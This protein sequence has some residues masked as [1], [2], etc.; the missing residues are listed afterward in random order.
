MKTN[1]GNPVDGFA[2]MP[3]V[4]NL[5]RR[6][7]RERLI[8]AGPAP[9]ARRSF[10]NSSAAAVVILVTGQPSD[11]ALNPKNLMSQG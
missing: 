11:P 4:R 5:R 6:Q 2:L 9:S 3:A 8:M 1:F 10:L 7:D